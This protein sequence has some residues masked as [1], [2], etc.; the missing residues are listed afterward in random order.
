MSSAAAP[1]IRWSSITTRSRARRAAFSLRMFHRS[2]GIM[3]IQAN[4]SAPCTRPRLSHSRSLR[5]RAARDHHY[6]IVGISSIIVNVGKVREM[7]RMVRELSPRLDDRRRRARRG[8]PGRRE[9]DR[10]RPHRERRRHRLDA[11]LPGRR[12]ERAHP[13]PR[14]R[15]R[16]SHAH[17]GRPACRSARARPR[18]PSFPRSAV[19]WAATSARPR[20][21]SAARE[22]S[23]TSTKAA[24]SCSTS[25]SRWKQS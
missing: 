6:D 21:S 20:P 15:L 23:S 19:P 14:H 22:S 4:I 25:C 18:R 1:S 9:D 17:H 7:C 5:A 11:A 12:R 8:H 10:C 13:P 2:W 24:R 3:M 16:H